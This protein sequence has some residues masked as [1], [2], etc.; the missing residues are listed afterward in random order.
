MTPSDCS[1]GSAT[2]GHPLDTPFPPQL[3]LE[4]KKRIVLKRLAEAGF[5]IND[6]IK[7]GLDFLVYTDTPNKVHSRYG[8]LIERPMT[9]RELVACQRIC[10][11]NNKELLIARVNSDGSVKYYRWTRFYVL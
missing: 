9:F 1:S 11:S 6:G 3:Q 4:S 10:A 7:Y 2:G 8:L 5:H